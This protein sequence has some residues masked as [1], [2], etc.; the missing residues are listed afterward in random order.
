VP[1][2]ETQLSTHHWILFLIDWPKVALIK[3]LEMRSALGRFASDED[4]EAPVK[5]RDVRAPLLT[6]VVLFLLLGML[7]YFD[8]RRFLPPEPDTVEMICHLQRVEPVYDHIVE[9]ELRVVGYLEREA[10]FRLFLYATHLRRHVHCQFREHA[11]EKRDYVYSRTY[12]NISGVDI[13]HIITGVVETYPKAYPMWNYADTP[14]N[15]LRNYTFDEYHL[16]GEGIDRYEDATTVYLLIKVIVGLFTT[17]VTASLFLLRW[18]LVR[19]RHQY[20]WHY[21]SRGLV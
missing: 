14:P 4:Q 3:S 12:L 21:Q 1:W 11:N 5:V 13:A 20:Q 6:G 19:C 2:Q 17:I 15:T 9:A 18:V 16:L 8:H 10:D 7:P